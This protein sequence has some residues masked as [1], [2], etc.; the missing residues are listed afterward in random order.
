MLITEQCFAD[1]ATVTVAT[2]A[3][4]EQSDIEV[5]SFAT[6]T[7]AIVATIEPCVRE[8]QTGIAQA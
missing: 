7:V 2:V 6:V 8:R 3:T 4:V 1:T 5:L